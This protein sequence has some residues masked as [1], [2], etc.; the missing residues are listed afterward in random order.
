MYYKDILYIPSQSILG[1]STWN[2]WLWQS[3]SLHC[4]KLWQVLR[5]I[6]Q[7]FVYWEYSL[8]WCDCDT[9]YWSYFYC[10]WGVH[11]VVS[12]R[13]TGH[14]DTPAVTWWPEWLQHPPPGNDQPTLDHTSLMFSPVISNIRSSVG[15]HHISISRMMLVI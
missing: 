15:H 5:D 4:K 12:R 9:I 13:N 2:P 14:L 11:Q 7:A 3:L 1:W 10:T 6:D 8:T